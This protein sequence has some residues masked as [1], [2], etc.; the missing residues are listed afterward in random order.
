MFALVAGHQTNQISEYLNG[1]ASVNSE[2]S[3]IKEKICENPRHLW[4]NIFSSCICENLWHLW[5]N[6]FSSCICE[7]PRHLWENIFSSCICENLWHLWENILSSCIRDI[8]VN[9]RVRR[10][11]PQITRIYTDVGAKDVEKICENLWHL[12]ENNLKLLTVGRSQ[13]IN[14]NY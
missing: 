8:H 10:S 3:V 7:N 9:H 12:W 4:E 1:A 11:L 2:E 14:N 6:I 5:E 13:L